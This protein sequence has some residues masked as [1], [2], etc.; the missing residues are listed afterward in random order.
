MGRSDGLRRLGMSL[1]RQPNAIHLEV[2]CVELIL[3]TSWQNPLN[4]EELLERFDNLLCGADTLNVK[5]TFVR[6]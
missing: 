3:V 2:S 5:S 1:G 4:L 6:S